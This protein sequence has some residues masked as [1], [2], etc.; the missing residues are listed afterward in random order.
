MDKK[1]LAASG[2]IIVIVSG[3]MLVVLGFFAFGAFGPGMDIEL[4]TTDGNYNFSGMMNTFM[5]LSL[6]PW[7]GLVNAGILLIVAGNAKPRAA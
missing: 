6:V 1:I 3:F 7:I 4:V 5:T 2:I